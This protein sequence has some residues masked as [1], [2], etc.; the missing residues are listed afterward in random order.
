MS[1][2]AFNDD[3]L[4]KQ[5]KSLDSPRRL[6]FMASCCQRLLPNYFAFQRQEQWGDIRCLQ[7]ALET[8]WLVL[9]GTLIDSYRIRQL[10][11]ACDQATPD[12]E[13]FDSILVSSALDACN[14][15][16]A[17]LSYILNPEIDRVVEVG[18]FA[19]D[20]V[21][22]Y[23][24]EVEGM[25]PDAD[26]LEAQILGHPLMQRELRKQRQDLADLSHVTLL[27]AG[28]LARLREPE[29]YAGKSNLDLS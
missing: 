21:D 9:S 19:T 12:T 16:S 8:I 25:N 28:I 14:S 6:A 11:E 15:V 4:R 5:L 20:T 2:P 22:M 29:G 1:L 18:R 26:D 7:E 13:D 24:Q 17:S 23:V 27:D 3:E 10:L